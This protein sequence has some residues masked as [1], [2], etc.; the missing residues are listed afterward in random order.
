MKI[1]LAIIVCSFL[2]FGN[3][4]PRTGAGVYTRGGSYGAGYVKQQPIHR[5]YSHKQLNTVLVAAQSYYA[6][7]YNLYGK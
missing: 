2:A 3:S 5:T 1:C 6:P 7:S 4:I